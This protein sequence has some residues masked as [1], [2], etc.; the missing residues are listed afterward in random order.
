[1]TNRRDFLKKASML[2]AGGVVGSSILSGCGS[3][4][5]SAVSTA[6]KKHIGIQLY[7][8]KD[9]VADLGI[10]PVLEIV[11]K[12]GYTNLETA[13]YG[14]G[15]FYGI[16]PAEFKK[17]VE[18]LGMRVTSSHLTR[19]ISDDRD[20]DMSWWNRATEAHA[21]A[22]MKYMVMPIAPFE[23]PIDATLDNVK[24]YGAYFSQI[25]MIASASSMSFGYHNHGFE[26]S[27]KIDGVPLYDLLIENMNTRVVHMQNDVYWTNV[28]GYNPLDYLK[29]YPQV[30][31]TL[32]IK[33][34]KAIGDSGKLD[35]KAIFEQFYAN[36]G[37]DWYMEQEAYDGTPQEGVKRS[38]DFLNAANFVV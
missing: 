8:L 15:M 5:G 12:M 7:S 17:I 27:N 23:D 11:A 32:H 6:A 3:R 1:M 38:F 36:G 4:G 20:A 18:D 34:D 28:G 9:D 25:G 31:K 13:D 33:D 21:E 14:R 16:A 26:F 19:Y 35:F 10:R 29:K 24:R 2:V 30:I 22:G 37:R